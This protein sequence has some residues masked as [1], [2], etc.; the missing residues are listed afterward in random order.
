MVCTGIWPAHPLRG[1][2]GSTPGSRE[3]RGHIAVWT[4]SHFS[5]GGACEWGPGHVQLLKELPHR[6]PQWLHRGHTHRDAILIYAL[7]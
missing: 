3:H 1:Q 6:F 5:W 2:S 7:V 4:R